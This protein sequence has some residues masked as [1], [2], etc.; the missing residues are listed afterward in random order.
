[1]TRSV[2]EV[3][4]GMIQAGVAPVDI[5]AI[6]NIPL[7]K[8][9]EFAPVGVMVADSK[10]ADVLTSMHQELT[11]LAYQTAIQTLREGSPTAKMQIVKTVY[12]FNARALAMFTPKEIDSLRD[13]FRNLIE[14]G[15]LEEDDDNG[16]SSVEEGEVE[17]DSFVGDAYYS[18]QRN[19][20]I[21][22]VG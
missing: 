14:K 8:V 11:L 2:S 6:L 10:E 5:A 22:E 19:S 3:I 1:M 15:S 9:V 7:V 20:G 4:G 17:A 12:G 13:E 16:I 18:G 21:Q